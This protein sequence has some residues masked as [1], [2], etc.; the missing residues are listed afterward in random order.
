MTLITAR[1]LKRRDL[2]LSFPRRHGP[3]RSRSGRFAACRCPRHSLWRDAATDSRSLILPL[4][5]AVMVIVGLISA[6][7]TAI[8]DRN[9]PFELPSVEELATVKSAMLITD[10]GDVFFELFPDIAPWHVANFKYL[11]DKG[12]YR[13]VPLKVAQGGYL[14]QS[15]APS[16][17]WR[18]RLAYSLPPEFSDLK[19]AVG[20]LGMG[21]FEDAMNPSRR[22]SS[23]V[24]QVLLE[25]N[26][27]MDGNYT[28]FGKVT[29]GL[30]VLRRIRE[31]DRIRELRVY[32][33][34]SSS[35]RNGSPQPP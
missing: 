13:D 21:R 35:P 2:L 4:A 14:V 18:D 32:V 22:S 8:A 29:H 31:G 10:R 33:R 23:T 11:A 15:G 7:R 20:T 27:R 16:L 26:A 9:P 5:F 12:V 30:E 34:K 1:N 19:H 28:A 25:E 6:P 24:F 3:S 17:A